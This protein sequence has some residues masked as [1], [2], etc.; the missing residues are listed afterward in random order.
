MRAFAQFFVLGIGF[1]A[2]SLA[3]NVLMTGGSSQKRG[4]SIQF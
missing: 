2:G 1:I 4:Y 3:I